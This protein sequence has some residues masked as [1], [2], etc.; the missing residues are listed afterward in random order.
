[1]VSFL[2]LFV[3]HKFLV[4]PFGV[5]LEPAIARLRSARM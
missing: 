4:A 2:C 1:M 5:F 3:L